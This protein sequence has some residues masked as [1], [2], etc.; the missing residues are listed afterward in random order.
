MEIAEY[1]GGT[2]LRRYIPGH[3]ID[4]RVAMIDVG[5][6]MHYYHMNRLGSVQ[7]LA[8]G[9]GTIADQYLYTPF[10]IEEPLV[11][12]DNPFRYTGRRFDPE[13]G[14]LLLPRALL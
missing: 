13:T 14:L 8:G 3:A 2:L 12:S 10:G 11:T 9:T 4:Q 6:G 5:G 1:D 7:A